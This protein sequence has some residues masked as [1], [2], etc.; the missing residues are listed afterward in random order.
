MFKLADFPT[1][2]YTGLAFFPQIE[3]ATSFIQTSRH[4]KSF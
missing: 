2:E 3:K 1:T 4:Y